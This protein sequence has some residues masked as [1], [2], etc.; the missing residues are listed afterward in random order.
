[1]SPWRPGARLARRATEIM[2]MLTWWRPGPA[3]SPSH[4]C[5][6]SAPLLSRKTLNYFRNTI[7]SREPRFKNLSLPVFGGHLVSVQHPIGQTLL[8]PIK[9]YNQCSNYIQ[10]TILSL[11]LRIFEQIDQSLPSR[12]IGNRANNVPKA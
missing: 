7:N 12:R 9:M 8:A 5:A 1:M 2:P 6:R 11:K 4:L 10:N 3:L